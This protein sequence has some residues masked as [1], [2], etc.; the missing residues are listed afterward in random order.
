MRRAGS[1][2]D[3]ASLGTEESTGGIGAAATPAKGGG[4]YS[5][6]WGAASSKGGRSP[7]GQVGPLGQ[8]EVAGR[9]G[10]DWGMNMMIDFG[11]FG[12]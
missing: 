5:Q 3:S 1:A 9:L 2:I 10:P 4:G 7:G 11:L 12:C 6:W 8:T